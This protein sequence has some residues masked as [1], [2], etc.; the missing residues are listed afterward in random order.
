MKLVNLC[1]QNL[2]F[3]I[4][5]GSIMVV[6]FFPENRKIQT[7]IVYNLHTKKKKKKGEA[8]EFAAVLRWT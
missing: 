6:I 5:Y 1:F 3:S 2:T 4:Y 8:W 7:K